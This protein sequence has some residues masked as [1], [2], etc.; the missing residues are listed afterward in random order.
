MLSIPNWYLNNVQK[1]YSITEI[2]KS[3]SQKTPPLPQRS[4]KFYSCRD[5]EIASHDN[6]LCGTITLHF[7]NRHVKCYN[8]DTTHN[9]QTTPHNHLNSYRPYNMAHKYQRV[10]ILK[11]SSNAFTFTCLD[12]ASYMQYYRPLGNRLGN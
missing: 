12:I 7:D 8:C 10:Y 4:T 6:I 5:S 11:S 3:G 9:F 1:N 2:L